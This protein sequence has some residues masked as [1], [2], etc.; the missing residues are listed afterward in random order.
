M[1]DTALGYGK[2]SYTST[3]F[4]IGRDGVIEIKRVIE[5][6]VNGK[7]DEQTSNFILD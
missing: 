6:G 3:I 7:M 4:C 5:R 1:N 2:L